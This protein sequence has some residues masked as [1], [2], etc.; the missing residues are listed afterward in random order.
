M[1]QQS[2]VFDYTGGEQTFTA[3]VSGTYKLEV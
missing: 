3:P 1:V 2:G